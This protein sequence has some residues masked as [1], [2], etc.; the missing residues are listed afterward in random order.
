[1]MFEDGE[2]FNRYYDTPMGTLW[3]SGLTDIRG[4]HLILRDVLV[5]PASGAPVEMGS[6]A[7]R[8]SLRSLEAEIRDQGFQSYELNAAREYRRK[9]ERIIS[10]SRRVR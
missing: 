9:P 2:E 7:V 3:V 4:S 8:S 6:E 1:M 10:I 5:Y